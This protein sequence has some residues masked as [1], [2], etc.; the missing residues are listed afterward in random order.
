MLAQRLAR[1]YNA[2]LIRQ[3][4]PSLPLPT[5]QETTYQG[6]PC[7]SFASNDYLGLGSTWPSHATVQGG[8]T[9][10]RLLSGAYPAL[11]S[12]ESAFASWLG[13]DAALMGPSG[14]QV[15]VGVLSSVLT[16]DDVVFVD[17][18]IHAS[19][20]DG[21]RLSGAQV[22]RFPHGQV[23]ALAHR[24]RHH[25]HQ[26]Q[27]A[28]LVIEALYSMAGDW[29]PLADMVAVAKDHDCGVV[30]D[31]AHSLGIVGPEGR[32][33]VAAHG[34]QDQV[35]IW[36]GAFGKA[37]GSA[38]GIV[39]TSTDWMTWLQSTA[40]PLMFSTAPFPGMVERNHAILSR[41]PELDGARHQLA[42]NSQLA[43]GI[44]GSPIVSW[45]QPSVA[46]AQ[47]LATRLWAH[48]L[49]VP[50]IQYPTVPKGRPQLRLSLSACHDPADIQRVMALSQVGA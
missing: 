20:W 29:A 32:G 43:G 42:R 46:H 13:Y 34:L 31:E 25:R 35:D 37:W 2:G 36:L 17:K 23:D 21:I 3:T 6:V 4:R 38:G 14:Y 44:E 9:G 7:V 24:L 45:P 10:S 47:A 41:M 12:F 19:L 33:W 11:G 39:A 22:V 30:V 28:F 16:A 50:V 40:R 27:L 15:N 5:R 18:S 1:L 26:G 48:R 49:W 8:A